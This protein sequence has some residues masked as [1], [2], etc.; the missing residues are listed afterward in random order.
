VKDLVDE[1]TATA[2]GNILSHTGS[3]STNSTTPAPVKA[4][5]DLDENTT[6]G[7]V[8]ILSKMKREGTPVQ[9][10]P[11]EPPI[12]NEAEMK[13]AHPE[14]KAWLQT[15]DEELNELLPTLSDKEKSYLEMIGSKSYEEMIARIEQYTGIRANR[16][17]L[18]SL[19]SIMFQTVQ[20]IRRIE[21]T[22][23][24][25]IESLALDTVLEY[26]EFTMV[27]EAYY[28]DEVKFDVKLELPSLQMPEEKEPE[29]GDLTDL[30]KANLAF[31]GL[32]LDQQKIKRRLANLLIQGQAVNKLYLFNLI[33]EQ[34]DAIDPHLMNLYGIIASTAQLG[35]WALPFGAE[36]AALANPEQQGGS[37]EVTP[38]EDK[39]L[40]KVRG[41]SLNILIHELVKGIYEWISLDPA[42]KQAMDAEHPS[43][44]VK[45]IIAGPELAKAFMS[46]FSPEK[47]EIVPLV[48]KKF[49]QLDAKDVKE[50]FAKSQRGKEVMQELIDDAEAEWAEYHK[51]KGG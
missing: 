41:Q 30:E 21:S 51:Q 1:R 3:D 14:K 48:H 32:D 25:Q 11:V 29:E 9:E 27:K 16:M 23:K 36:L 47:H 38:K 43:S 10:E 12:V 33:K 35:Y 19:I 24:H 49:L 26:P 2:L 8:S 39:Y 15:G 5:G 40:I 13:F 42:L 50:V 34:I 44:E 28:N 22:H 20:E 4:K 18:P 7:L 46:Y 17:N 31:T 37:E 6:K 45:D